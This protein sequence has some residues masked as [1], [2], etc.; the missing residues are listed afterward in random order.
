MEILNFKKFS[1]FE[2]VNS[3]PDIGLGQILNLRFTEKNNISNIK[4]KMIE[5]GWAPNRTKIYH[6]F[7]II[8][9]DSEKYPAGGEF[10]LPM[11]FNNKEESFLICPYYNESPSLRSTDELTYKAHCQIVE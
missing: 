8:E 3:T 6:R 1:I 4:V 7:R 9:T 5:F 10:I 11:E 2:L